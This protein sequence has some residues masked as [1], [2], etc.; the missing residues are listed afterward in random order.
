MD[1]HRYH[2]WDLQLCMPLS[3]C[4]LQGRMCSYQC[5]SINKTWK[6][7]KK[8]IPVATVAGGYTAGSGLVNGVLDNLREYAR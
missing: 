1:E 5:I 4:S 2:R 7:E 8:G 6:P 3:T